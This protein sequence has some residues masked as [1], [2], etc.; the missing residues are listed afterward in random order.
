[1]TNS[2]IAYYKP[3]P[4][5]LEGKS[6]KDQPLQ[7][8][9]NYLV[10]LHRSGSVIMGGPYG[11]GSGGLVVFAAD[12]IIDVNEVVSRDPTVAEGIL[13]ASVKQWSRIV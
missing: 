10:E 6:L 13:V 4:N 11:D 2:Y 9:V 12:D 5:W 1:M 7:K 3:G 8:H